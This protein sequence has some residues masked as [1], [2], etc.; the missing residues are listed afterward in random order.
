MD[1]LEEITDGGSKLALV[2]RNGYTPLTTGFI[3]PLEHAQQVGFIVYPKGGRVKR[4]KHLPLKRSI[5]GTA[6]TLI[7]RKGSAQLHLYNPLD[8]EVA[9]VDL[10]EGDVAILFRGGHGLDFTEDTIILE[11]KQGPYL[12]EPEKKWF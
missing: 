5:I 3:T 10:C 6:E 7:V 12:V 11:I 8:Q 1:H 4:H 9:C 2:V